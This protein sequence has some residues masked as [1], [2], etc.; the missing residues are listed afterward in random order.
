MVTTQET[1][2]L[3]GTTW[4]VVSWI[5]TDTK[6]FQSAVVSFYSNGTMR[7]TETLA[8][9]QIIEKNERFRIVGQTLIV[10]GGFSL[11]A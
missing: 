4:Q 8:D 2:P 10:D 6:Q 7:S 3:A 1:Y 11:P 5:P 9:G